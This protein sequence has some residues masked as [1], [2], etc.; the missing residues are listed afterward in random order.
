MLAQGADGRSRLVEGGGQGGDALVRIAHL[1]LAVVAQGLRLLGLFGG[2]A[3]VARHFLDG[4]AELF[5][6]GADAIQGLLLLFGRLIA[7][8]EQVPGVV[9]MG[10]DPAAAVADARHHG[11]QARLL[12][13][14]AQLQ[15]ADFVDPPGVDQLLD[16][17]LDD[18]PTVRHQR[19]EGLAVQAQQQP[20]EAGARG[21][22]GAAQLR[23]VAQGE[24]AER[25]EG[26]Q[27]QQGLGAL[28]AQPLPA[29]CRRLLALAAGAVDGAGALDR[30]GLGQA[31]DG[32]V[33]AHLAVFQDR[34][35]KGVDPERLAV[36]PAVLQ[37]AHP[38]LAAAEGRPEILDRSRRHLRVAQAGGGTAEQGAFAEAG[39]T[40]QGRAGIEDVGLAVGQQQQLLLGLG[41]AWVWRGLGHGIRSV[42]KV[43]ADARARVAVPRGRRLS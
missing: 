40:A 43:A 17:V 25:A 39:Q 26:Q 19:G 30:L 23:T 38:G 29:Q 37:H 7:G 11:G 42:V 3:G 21:Q 16:R 5:D 22:H 18:A 1:A 24:Q 14:V 6:R 41:L 2:I 8:A 36:G 4:R 15:L 33:F 20:A 35:D 31:I 34:A 32:L 13:A 27:R 9:G 28:A 12:Q 10:T